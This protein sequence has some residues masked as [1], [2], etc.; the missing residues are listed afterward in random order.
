[1]IMSGTPHDPKE[2]HGFA[3]TVP[4]ISPRV[5]LTR[6]GELQGWGADGRL[7]G[8]FRQSMSDFLLMPVEGL[9]TLSGRHNIN[10]PILDVDIFSYPIFV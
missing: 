5:S 10:N 4:I 6:L 9:T 3:I 7:V 1:M 8:M 2:K